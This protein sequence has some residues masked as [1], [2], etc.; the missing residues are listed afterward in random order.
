MHYFRLLFLLYLLVGLNNSI[1]AQHTQK[2]KKK[3]FI[4]L[5]SICKE[6]IYLN[7]IKTV[8]LY[9]QGKEGDFPAINLYSNEQLS[10]SFDDL[11][12]TVKDYYITIIHCNADWSISRLSPLEYI[13][14]YNEDQITNIHPSKATLQPYIHYQYLFPNNNIKPKIA[15]NYLLKVYADADKTNIILTKYMYVINNSGEISSQIIPSSQ[16]DKKDHYQ[17]ININ[18][19]PTLSIPN[20]ERDLKIHIF[21]NQRSDNLQSVSKPTFIGVNELQYNAINTLEFAGNNEFRYVDLRLLNSETAPQNELIRDSI[22]TV[23]LLVDIENQNTKYTS[24]Y[25]K[26]GNYYIRNTQYR[27]EELTSDYI[28]VIFS[29]Q[30]NTIIDGNIYIVG[31][32]N[33]FKRNINNKLIFDTKKGLWTSSQLLKQG[34]YDYEYILED[35]KGNIETNFFSGSHFATG[36]DYQIV[37]YLQKVDTYWDE[38]I[39]YKTI[40][41]NNKNTKN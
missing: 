7:S 12:R 14:G 36:N 31:R 37:I 39:G 30:T 2:T 25:D 26:N 10:L 33:D 11:D 32:F 23:V 22:L 13:V 17:K 4:E 28:N 20:P 34:V 19:K 15:G 6:N 18:Y 35:K 9:P 16:S 8:Q 38:I 40:N 27:Q 41:I 3:H 24:T 5:E 21:Q 1:V 29:L